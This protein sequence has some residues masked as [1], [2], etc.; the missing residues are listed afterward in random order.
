MESVPVAVFA[1]GV[2]S[3]GMHNGVVRTQF[4]QLGADGTP[5]TVL[6]LFLPESQLKS[7]V[8]G[9]SKAIPKK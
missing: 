7:I 8:D 1:D 3:I 6:D 9:L 2:R 4:F 5:Q